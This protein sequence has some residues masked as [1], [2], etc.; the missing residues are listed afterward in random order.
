MAKCPPCWLSVREAG[1]PDIDL[2][3]CPGQEPFISLWQL[4]RVRAK[5]RLPLLL[6]HELPLV[7]GAT[8]STAGDFRAHIWKKSGYTPD[9]L[10]EQ[11]LDILSSVRFQ[12]I[13]VNTR[14]LTSRAYPDL[15]PPQH[16]LDPFKFAEVAFSLSNQSLL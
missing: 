12:H 8:L 10:S 3:E 11:M 13:L 7:L 9:M 4:K 14:D 15:Y 1:A 5:K 6:L 16:G 2:R